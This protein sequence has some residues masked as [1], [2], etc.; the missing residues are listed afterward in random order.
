MPNGLALQG[1]LCLRRG[2]KLSAVMLDFVLST[3]CLPDFEMSMSRKC[4]SMY[5]AVCLCMGFVS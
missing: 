1:L 5:K 2:L 3:L 4:A